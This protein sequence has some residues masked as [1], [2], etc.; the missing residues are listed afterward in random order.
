M[1]RMSLAVLALVVAVS[2]VPAFAQSQDP[3]IVSARQFSQQGNHDTAIQM[4]RSGLASR[5]NDQ[6]LKTE[7][8]NVLQLKLN[9]LEQQLRLLRGEISALRGADTPSVIGGRATAR[10][11]GVPLAGCGGPAS[12]VRVGGDIKQPQKIRD[13]KAEYPPVAQEARV[14]G[15]VILEAEIDCEGNVADVRVL[16]GQPLLND[17]AVTA[18]RQWRYTPT[19][20]NGM[21]VPVIMTV[22]VTFTLQ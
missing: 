1:R 12:A 21:P 15:V 11:A 20:N 14:Q 6:A 16:R 5:P 18:V 3:L 8:G 2:A 17:A 7:L 22:T 4:L 13:Q 9:A 19:L 10:A